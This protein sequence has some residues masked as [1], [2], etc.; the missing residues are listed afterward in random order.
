MDTE[1][2]TDLKISLTGLF[3]KTQLTEV[4][5]WTEMNPINVKEVD[6]VLKLALLAL[7]SVCR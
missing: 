2:G 3:R 4:K 1:R 5:L 7:C 6:F